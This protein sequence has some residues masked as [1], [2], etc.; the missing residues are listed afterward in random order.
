M[1]D[2]LADHRFG[3]TV[4]RYRHDPENGRVGLELLPQS[5]LAEAVTRRETLRGLPFIDAM[6]GDDPWPASSLDSLVQVKLAGEGYTEGF[7]QGHTMRQSPST[8]AF[9]YV[10][11]TVADETV[12]TVLRREDGCELRHRLI[13]APR[14]GTFRIESRF[15]NG[16]SHAVTLEMLSSFS[17]GNIT[18]FAVDDAPGRLRAHRFRSVWSAEGRLESRS[19]EE[20]HLERSW[21]GAGAFSERFGQVGSMPVRRWFPFLALEDTQ[22]GVCWGA[23]LAWAGSWQMEIFRQ[24]DDVAM[25]G[26]LADRE[27]GHWMKTLP[28]G[29]T[30]EAPPATLACVS[31]GLGDLCDRLVSA[32]AAALATQPEVERDLP[33]V[34]NEWCTTWGEPQHERLLAIAER[35]AMTPTRYLVID[36]GWYKLDGGSWSTGHGDWQPNARLFPTGI[37]GT[38]AAIRARGLIPGLWF[39]MET[40]GE[41]SEAYH[42]QTD[43]LLHR[44]GVPVT[45]RGRRFWDLTNPAAVDYLTTHVIDLL[46]RGGFGYL[47]VDYNETI[48][49]GSTHPDSLGE[50]LRQH[51]EG[52]HRFFERIRARLP[53]LVIEN[54][55][56]GGHRL[57]PSMI[58]R[59][60]MSSF[61]DAHEL[62][63]IPLIAANLHALML[64]RQSQI[65]AVLH[66]ADSQRRLV[67]SLAATFLG[68]MCLSGEIDR[69][70]D[71]QWRTVLAAQALYG[72][73]APVIRAGKSVRYGQWGSS[74]R[75]P[76]GWQAVVRHGE[77]NCV[78]L[79]LHA[80][81]NAPDQ[82]EIPLPEGTWTVLRI[83]GEEVSDWR[84]RAEGIQVT[85][86]GDFS[87]VVL[88]LEPHHG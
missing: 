77:D 8:F 45:V 22:T 42:R 37:E 33:I 50:G 20:L 51:I 79:V 25:S 81:A 63:E 44:D 34:F 84:L 57:E 69:L 1:S 80:F 56:S 65:W 78:L 12:E 18:P 53:D 15:H 21:S 61:S 49:L 14:S 28:P 83:F 35:L 26:G 17:L 70:D 73:A 75:Y 64:P 9:R 68:R 7:A 60:A 72:E 48:G 3:D 82:V 24:N 71:A 19:L 76:T 54:C 62:V 5:R 39:E 6:P 43:L 16:S 46:E 27:F 10:G 13:Y 52:V 29:E 41:T 87:A 88:L 36:A 32:Q 66:A 47:K 86:P 40:V 38:A 23:Q 31:G 85:V 55:S 59:T 74:W 2:I 67:Y 11:Q 58:G 4:A 30:L